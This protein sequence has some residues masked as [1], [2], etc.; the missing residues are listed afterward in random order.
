MRETLDFMT[1][2]FIPDPNGA[3]FETRWPTISRSAKKPPRTRVCSCRRSSRLVFTSHTRTEPSWHATAN[4]CPSGLKTTDWTSLIPPISNRL[5]SAARLDVEDGSRT[6]AAAC[7]QVPPVW[8]EGDRQNLTS[9][10]KPTSLFAALRVPD[11][12]RTILAPPSQSLPVW[13]EGYGGHAEDLVVV[14][15]SNSRPV[16]TSQT[17]ESIS[18]EPVAT[19]SPSGAKATER[20][21]VPSGSTARRS[22]VRDATSQKMSM[23]SWSIEARTVP[24]GEYAMARTADL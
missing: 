22:S 23:P 24:S 6:I 1:R 14:D 11:S 18:I 4:D 15:S 13:S 19:D 10:I 21:R 5:R 7:C 2:R 8:A 20:K 17:R 12:D 9:S 3:V 16:F